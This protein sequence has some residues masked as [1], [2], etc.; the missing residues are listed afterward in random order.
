MKWKFEIE[1]EACDWASK[2]KRLE[3]GEKKCRWEKEAET[4]K[5]IKEKRVT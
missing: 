2:N 4:E 1:G 5:Y 3:N